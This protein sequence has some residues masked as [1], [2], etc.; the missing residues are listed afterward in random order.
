MRK[1][2][3]KRETAET[4]IDLSL[5]LDGNIDESLISTGVGFLDHMLA[6]F[7]SY[8]GIE[9]KLTC[10][11]DTYVDDHHSVE[12]VGITLGMALR[13]ALGDK[14]GIC[15]F[16]EA[17]QPMDESLVLT[18]LDISG[19]GGFYTDLHFLTEKIG[20]FDTELVAEF[21]NAL[22]VNA[23]LTLH[24]RQIAG[25]NS[26]HI[27][28][29]AFKGLGRAIRQAVTIDERFNDKIPSTKGSLG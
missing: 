27:A 12:D 1:A 21:M 3:I 22:A 14:R 29:A 2:D 25:T 10:V 17:Y 7:A 6:L 15:R 26:H 24:I 5:D 4:K 11:G 19:R 28:E 18:A 20:S 9:L 13:E 8:A 16:G 23:G